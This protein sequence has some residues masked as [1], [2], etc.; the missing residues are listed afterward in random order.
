[1]FL[2]LPSNQDSRVKYKHITDSNLAN[3]YFHSV[4][5]LKKVA[6]DEKLESELDLYLVQNPSSG[7]YEA[8]IYYGPGP[9]HKDKKGFPSEMVRGLSWG[10]ECFDS[11][12][13]HYMEL[14]KQFSFEYQN[15]NSI[16]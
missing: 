3:R 13:D 10:G 6:T 9:R 5:C 8:A 15:D 12:V 2:S 16:Q 14:V 1:M 7:M 4:P 11:L